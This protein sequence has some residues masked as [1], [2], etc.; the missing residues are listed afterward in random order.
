MMEWC[1]RTQHLGHQKVQWRPMKQKPTMEHTEIASNHIESQLVGGWA[2]P[3]EKWWSS[4][5]GIMTF[6]TEWKV[7]QNSMVPVTTNQWLLT[8]NHH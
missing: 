7:I 6:P 2:N 4:S 3:S 1:P 8:I 5:V